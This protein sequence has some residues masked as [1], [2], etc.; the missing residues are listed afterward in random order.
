[1]SVVLSGLL[2]YLAYHVIGGARADLEEVAVQ[3]PAAVA[4]GMVFI[5]FV[6][7][8]IGKY[9]AG[10]A[11][12]RGYRL[13]RAAGGYVLGNVIVAMLIA[14][15][16]AMYY[17]GVSWGETVLTYVIPIL[18]ALVAL[19]ILLNLVLDIYRPRV[20]GRE[21]RPPY[22]SRLLGLF[23]EP[24][25]V[26]RTVAATLDYQFGFKVSETWFYR[27][28]ERAILPLL[29]IQI[30]S[31][32]L[33]TTIV[34]VD[35]DE[36]AFI[37]KFGSPYVSD[38]DASRGVRA[39]VFKPGFYLKAPWPFS[40][41]RHVPA[42][43][44]HSVELGK[45]RERTRQTMAVIPLMKEPDII[46]WS[47]RHIDPEE[48]FEVSFLVPSTVE[49]G[50]SEGAQQ[51]QGPAEE[52]VV[53]D[54]VAAETEQR[55]PEVNLARVLGHVHYRVKRKPDGDIDEN[56]AFAYYYRQADIRR[57]VEQLGYRALCRIAASQDFLKWIAE[58]REESVRQL[59]QEL[60]EAVEREAL[61]LEVVFVGIPMVHPPPETAAAYADVVTALQDRE[62]LRHEGE[63]EYNQTVEDARAQE[64]NAI[65]EAEGY[66]ARRTLPAQAEADQFL[67][68]LD[69]YRKAPTVYKFRTYF[70]VLEGALEGLKL[71]LAPD[72]PSEVLIIDLEEKLRPQLLEFEK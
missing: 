72:V 44:I 61:G 67:V 32:W 68:R 1:F 30:L 33:L 58:D 17:F 40:V 15:S 65:Y 56:A 22:D 66:A 52:A 29:L 46:L 42:Y 35:R 64:A 63:L 50:G 13:L 14:I 5:A 10:L 25:G 21:T 70:D 26:L 37:E 8:L 31:L 71:Y 53:D 27:F 24:E 47:E 19:E 39:T 45:I 49:T 38:A 4:V 51:A 48:G 18:M 11:Q 12:S 3:K 2:L 60:C 20:A 23:G 36:I 41:A 16:M 62:S 34:V 57:H 28:M 6:G 43:R 9:A 69:A 54:D 55:A 7:F 59:R